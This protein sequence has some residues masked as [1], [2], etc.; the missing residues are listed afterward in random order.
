MTLPQHLL[1]GIL[2]GLAYGGLE[3]LYRGRTHPSMVLAGGLSFRAVGLLDQLAPGLPLLWQGVLG[4]AI[5]TALELL[6]GLAVNRRRTVWDYSACPCN[7]RG[8]ICLPYF[9]LWI[10]LA[11]AAAVLDDALALLLF[12]RLP[13]V[14][15]WV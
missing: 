11:L 5:I 12:H 14:Y 9:L 13:P 4:A 6:T 2:G 7:F 8:Q 3:L 15:R 1:L 10:P